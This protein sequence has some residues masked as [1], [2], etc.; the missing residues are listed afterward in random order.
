MATVLVTG[1]TGFIGEP[2]VTRLLEMGHVVHCLSRTPP[3]DRVAGL[4]W[5]ELD[6]VRDSARLRPV[7]QEVQATHLLHLA[8]DVT[9]P[10]YRSSPANLA[11]VGATLDLGQ[12]FCEAGGS[13]VVLAGT[14]AEH[15]WLGAGVDPA[16]LPQGLYA[17]SKF[18]VHTV[19]TQY[20]CDRA[21]SYAN[22]RLFFPFGPREYPQ[23]L[24]PGAINALLD[25]KPFHVNNGNA[26]RDFMYVRDAG[27]AYA[28]LLES[29]ADGAVDIGSG[30]GATLRE[31][32]GKIVEFTGA[33]SQLVSFGRHAENGQEPPVLVADATRL[34]D[35]VGFEPS[36]TL[37]EGV[38]QTVEW[39]R[40]VRVAGSSA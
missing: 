16:P 11:F 32:L 31:I 17:A 3:V 39:W 1:A 37:A 13:R 36:T 22:G 35:E 34:R 19:L 26:I 23:R 8:W 24:L 33:D 4:Y 30:N 14:C 10:S 7:L 38:K 18:A 25:G 2:A 21:V 12:A 9:P 5:H 29:S 27:R 6:L 40:S 20:C 15:E 28:A